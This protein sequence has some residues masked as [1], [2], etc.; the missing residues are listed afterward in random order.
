MER[1]GWLAVGMAAALM[2]PV[3]AVTVEEAYATLLPRR[4][5]FNP[6][7]S[8]LPPAEQAALQEI[9]RLTDAA[10]VE[11]L[12]VWAPLLAEER[13]RD[14]AREYGE[15]I[16]R[17]EQVRC[18]EALESVRAHIVAALAAQR[19]MFARWQATGQPPDPAADERLQA[20]S[21]RLL[22]AYHALL[23]RYPDEPQENRDAFF[24]TL[25]AADVL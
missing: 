20:A 18:P 17:L 16:H 8:T 10:T 11:R 6:A 1:S 9:F 21:Q 23:A 24:D 13:T 15:V 22:A 3:G 7:V 4:R 14:V 12:E 5:L 2:R 19:R 25:R